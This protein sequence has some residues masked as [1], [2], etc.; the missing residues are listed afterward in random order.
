MPDLATFRAHLDVLGD[1]ERAVFADAH[2]DVV[3]KDALLSERAV[4]RQNS[5]Q[6]ED[7]AQGHLSCTCTEGRS[8]S[9][10]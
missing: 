6:C 2:L 5:E 9:R 1:V 3:A 7:D 10:A 8:S 4:A